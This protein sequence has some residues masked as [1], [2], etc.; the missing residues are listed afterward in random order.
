[1]PH[2]ILLLNA[3]GVELFTLE[4]MKITVSY[5]VKETYELIE[6]STSEAL[7]SDHSVAIKHLV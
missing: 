4:T 3:Q 2:L 5:T 1:M 7:L 6:D